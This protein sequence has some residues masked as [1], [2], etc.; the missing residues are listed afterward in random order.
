VFP[1]PPNH[2]AKGASSLL[3]GIGYHGN[4]KAY[5]WAGGTLTATGPFQP[6]TGFRF[7]MN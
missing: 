6:R 4:F 3:A 2:A 7:S 1:A 5:T